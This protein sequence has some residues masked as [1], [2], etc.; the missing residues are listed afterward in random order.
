VVIGVSNVL[1]CYPRA[2]ES[3]QLPDVAEGAGREGF[4]NYKL[5]AR[6]LLPLSAD[7]FWGE[8]LLLFLK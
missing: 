2:D 4:F 5:S 1:F 6:P 3:G 8:V 7:Y